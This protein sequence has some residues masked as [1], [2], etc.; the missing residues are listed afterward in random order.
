MPLQTSDGESAALREVG[1]AEIAI[2]QVSVADEGSWVTTQSIQLILLVECRTTMRALVNRWFSFHLHSYTLH[3]FCWCLCCPALR[4]GHGFWD[5]QGLWLHRQLH[6]RPTLC[7]SID[8]L[9]CIGWAKCRQCGCAGIISV[10]TSVN[11]G[12]TQ[13]SWKDAKLIVIR[14]KIWVLLV[15]ATMLFRLLAYCMVGR[16]SFLC[17]LCCYTTLCKCLLRHQSLAIRH[18]PG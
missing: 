17:F 4:T 11:F 3:L 5:L 12:W 9:Y 15:V 2:D 10:S 14:N 6:C 13:A 7:C 8:L 1:P 16:I 18:L